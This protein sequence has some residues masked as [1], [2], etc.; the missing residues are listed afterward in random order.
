M[1]PRPQEAIGVPT[2]MTPGANLVPALALTTCIEFKPKAHLDR[3]L[4]PCS[5]T[6]SFYIRLAIFTPKSVNGCRCLG[7]NNYCRGRDDQSLIA[8]AQIRTSTLT[9]TENLARRTEQPG[10]S[11]NPT[12]QHAI[13]RPAV[14][15]F[16]KVRHGS[17]LPVSSELCFSSTFW[18]GLPWGR[19]RIW[20]RR[21]R[22][23]SRQQW[24]GQCE[25]T[26]STRTNST[27]ARNW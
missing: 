23:F 13:I 17:Q 21:G 4:V 24:G 3:S 20:R 14:L 25:W 27:P 8:A 18:R 11:L 26:N 2:A 10:R 9:H 6:E 7:Y 12:G 5:Q 16:L 22:Q 1:T 19:T 15:W